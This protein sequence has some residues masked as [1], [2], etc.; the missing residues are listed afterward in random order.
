MKLSPPDPTLRACVVVPARDEQ[1]LIAS[2]LRAL[3]AQTGIEMHEYEVLLVLDHCTDATADRA[4]QVA[5]AH[6]LFRLH[7]LDGPGLGSGHARRVGMDAACERLTGLCRPE[8]LIAST[9]ADTVVAHDWLFVQ[10]DATE[11]GARAI[12]GRI[13]LGPGSL[14]QS[15]VRWHSER[16]SSRHQKL[17]ADPDQLGATEHWQFSGASLALTAETYARVGGLEPRAALEDEGL[18]QVLRKERIPIERL[19]SVRATTSSRLDGRA[20]KG[21][22][23]DLAAACSRLNDA[24]RPNI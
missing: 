22:A 8:G 6:P 13:E 7:L 16:G 10:L 14:P 20:S 12:G 17:M 9:D 15:V 11:H 21:L 2:S 3:A 5:D 4:R 18:E 23:H 24:S 19:L 1:D